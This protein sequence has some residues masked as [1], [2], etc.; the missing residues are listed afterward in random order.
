MFVFSLK[1]QLEN[2]RL[3]WG[4]FEG[5]TW[6]LVFNSLF[7][8]FVLARF[9]GR[10]WQT[11]Y[12]VSLVIGHFCYGNWIF[13]NIVYFNLRNCTSWTFTWPRC[14]LLF[15]GFFLFFFVWWLPEGHFDQSISLFSL[16][17][18]KHQWALHQYLIPSKQSKFGSLWLFLFLPGIIVLF[19]E[20]WKP[21][22]VNIYYTGACNITFSC[23]F[24]HFIL[25]FNNI[26]LNPFL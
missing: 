12:S 25:S 17:H 24:Q 7:D 9:G 23:L 11:L 20:K 22:V 8:V 3:I 26:S 19:M 2:W 4:F 10:A 6:S 21:L 1:I 18:C 16:K 5:N 15:V 14:C 13:W